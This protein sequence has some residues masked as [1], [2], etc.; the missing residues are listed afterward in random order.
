MFAFLTILMMIISILLILVVLIQPGKGDMIS[1]MGGL[2]NQ[3]TSML[4][5]RKAM[6]LLTKIT[7]GFAAALLV[8]AVV[9]NKFFLPRSVNFVKPVTEGAAVPQTLPT[10]PVAPITQPQQQNQEQTPSQEKENK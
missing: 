8:L 2:T 6:D 7:I 3:F 9:T 5:T 10:K 1:G 4:G